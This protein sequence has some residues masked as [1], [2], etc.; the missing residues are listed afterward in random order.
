MLAVRKLKIWAQV[1]FAL[2]ACVTPVA[3]QWDALTKSEEL[4]LEMGIL[5]SKYAD[6]YRKFKSDFNDAVSSKRLETEPNVVKNALTSNQE[7]FAF[8][9]M[10]ERKIDLKETVELFTGLENESDYVFEKTKVYARYLAIKHLQNA[11]IVT[12][13]EDVDVAKIDEKAKPFVYVCASEGLKERYENLFH[14]Y[15]N[16]EVE[17]IFSES[18]VDEYIIV[19]C[20]PA[21]QKWVAW[22]ELDTRDTDENFYNLSENVIFSSKYAGKKKEAHV[23]SKVAQHARYV[24]NQELK[25]YEYNLKIDR[26]AER[27]ARAYMRNES[28]IAMQNAVIQNSINTQQKLAGADRGKRNVSPSY[29]YQSNNLAPTY[30]YSSGS[31]SS[32]SSSSGGKVWVRPY[33]RKD[34]THVRGHWRSAPSR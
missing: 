11:T 24:R 17:Y 16:E 33:T 29:G 12:T 2:L 3:A 8:Y 31:T 6:E 25:E 4:W 1:M 32:T 23:K 20:E 21:E 28:R 7:I 34:G 26:N 5:P 18:K 22:S 27:A 9:I 15:F 10:K 30:T 19:A 14:I 13:C